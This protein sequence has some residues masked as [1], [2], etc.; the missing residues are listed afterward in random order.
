MSSVRGVSCPFSVCLAIAG[1][2]LLIALW[3]PFPR[4]VES[5]GVDVGVVVGVCYFAICPALMVLAIGFSV[6]DLF[7]RR[8]RIQACVAICISGAVLGW[9]WLRPPL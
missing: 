8:D 6:R 3:L 2:L 7:L 4:W 9:Y 1:L 5:A